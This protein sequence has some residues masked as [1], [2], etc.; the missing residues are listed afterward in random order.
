MTYLVCEECGKYY[1]LDEGKS[2]FNFDKCECG[3]KLTYSDSLNAN[4]NKFQPNNNSNLKCAKCGVENPEGSKICFN[5]GDEISTARINNPEKSIIASISWAGVAVGFGFLLLTTLLTVIVIFGSN[6]PQKVEDIPYKLLLAFG[7]ISMIVAVI[8]GLISAYIGG[9][10]K[11]K[12]GIIN[13]GLVGVILGILV[14]LTSGSITFIGVI[15][16]FGSLSVL[17]GIFGTLLK[18]KL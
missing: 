18:R 1:A 3:G 15:A 13:G 11:Y 8:S 6:I 16:I 9:S 10:I 7:I 12:N 14:G 17:G 4:K 2:S 5:C